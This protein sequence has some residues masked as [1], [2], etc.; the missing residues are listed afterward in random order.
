[1]RNLALLLLIILSGCSSTSDYRAAPSWNENNSATVYL[2]RT[3]V[4]YHSLN[5]ERPFFYVDDKLV[6]KLGT[7][8]FVKFQ[9][10]PGEHFLSSKESIVFMPGN[11]SG[12]ISG[13][14]ESGKTYYFRYSKDFSS[15][16]ST[17]VGFVVTD[18]S[19]LTFATKQQFTNRT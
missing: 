11:E 16:S 12:R 9:V 7:G 14:F 5:P 4:Q 1:V 2:Y 3:D 17:G 18:E 10:S 19:S 8:D 13:M 15:V 6:A